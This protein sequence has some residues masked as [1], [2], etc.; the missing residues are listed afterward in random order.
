MG[1][2]SGFFVDLAR[3]RGYSAHGTDIENDV[4]SSTQSADIITCFQVLE[5]VSDPV[6]AIQ[7]LR[8]RFNRQL[9]ISVPNEPWFSFWRLGWEPEHL[10]AITPQA[11]QRQLG[12]PSFEATFLLKRYYV[13]IWTKNA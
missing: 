5:H 3:K 11:L 2:E 8:T 13:G 4:A 10:W 9:I 1:C 7:N 6:K 12:A